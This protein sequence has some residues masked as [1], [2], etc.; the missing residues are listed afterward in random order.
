ME[1]Y[2]KRAAERRE[3]AANTSAARKAAADTAELVAK[4]KPDAGVVEK[5]KG[6]SSGLRQRSKAPAG[7]SDGKKP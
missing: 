4:M 2:A 1:G 7:K 5:M 6:Q 3:A